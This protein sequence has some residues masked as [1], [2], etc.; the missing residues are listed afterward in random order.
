MKMLKRYLRTSFGMASDE[1][2][3]K[4]N[5]PANYPMVA[6]DY[7]EQRRALAKKIGL[8]RHSTSYRG[9]RKKL[10]IAT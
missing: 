3:A 4:W 7:T 6:P 8:G 2:R 10:S 1:Y 9:K 5:L